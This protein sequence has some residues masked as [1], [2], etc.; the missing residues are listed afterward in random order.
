MVP[1]FPYYLNN[2]SNLVNYIYTVTNFLFVFAK[3]MQKTIQGYKLFPFRKSN[4]H[5]VTFSSQHN[6]L[7]QIDQNV[8]KSNFESWAQLQLKIAA[9]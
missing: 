2:T 7:K 5:N 6:A 4:T 8:L 1:L 3:S 9:K